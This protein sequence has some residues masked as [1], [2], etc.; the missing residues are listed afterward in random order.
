MDVRVPLEVAPEGVE[1]DDESWD[2]PVAVI[3]VV[4]R[5]LPFLLPALSLCLLFLSLLFP[6]LCAVGNIVDS[7]PSCDEQ[8][9]EHLPVSQEHVPQLLRNRK[10]DMPVLAV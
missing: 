1:G 3:L 10:D 2:A 9:A 8:E 7:V 4:I 5:R 6:V